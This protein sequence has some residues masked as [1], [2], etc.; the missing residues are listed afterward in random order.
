MI[1]I[2]KSS[3]LPSKKER[4]LMYKLE[5]EP[6]LQKIVYDDGLYATMLGYDVL[7]TQVGFT[8]KYSNY[9]ILN[10]EILKVIK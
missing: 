2:L 6:Q 1:N 9:S 10:R 4:I 3:D 5:N 7:E 8:Q